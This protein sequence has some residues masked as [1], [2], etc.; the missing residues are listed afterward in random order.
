M[1]TGLEPD[2][3]HRGGVDAWLHPAEVD[4]LCT[5]AEVSPP[6]PLRVQVPGD[7]RASFQVAR[8]ELARRGLSDSRG[9]RGVAADLV[10]LLREGNGSLDIMVARR[11]RARGAL[12]L[13]QRD[14]ALLVAQ[15]LGPVGARVHLVRMATRDAVDA[16]LDLVPDLGAALAAGFNLPR[17]SLDQAYR[18]ILAATDDDGGPRRLGGD[19]LDR[20]LRAHGIDEQTAR[21]MTTHLQPVLGNGQAGVA[22]RRG[23]ADEWTRSG[24]E[25]RWLDTARGRFRL[26]GDGDWM[27][28]NPLPR[29]ELRGELRALA[30]ELW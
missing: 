20:L 9:P 29:E 10:H 3:G 4:L 2:A 1:P 12:V 13:A 21:R 14:E 19:E 24:A 26:A 28:V 17:R 8:A 15:D 16:L 7:R 30:R 27:S 5:F 23:Y 11:D 18:A 6:F 25:V 22:V